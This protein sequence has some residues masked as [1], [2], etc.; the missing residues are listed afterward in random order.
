MVWVDNWWHAQFRAN[1]VKPNACLDVT[2]KAVLH[3][4]PLPLVR[5]HP[6][7]PDLVDR[8]DTVVMAVVQQ[9]REMLKV[10]I[11]MCNAPIYRRTIRGPLDI[12]R[13]AGRQ[14]LFRKPFGIYESHTCQN[15][16]LFD[17]LDVLRSTQ[18]HRQ[19]PMA[20][21]VDLIIHYRVRKILYS[22]ATIDWNF[23]DW[24]QVISVIYGLWHTYKHGCNIIWRT[25]FPL[26][27]YITAP[28]F[29]A[30]ARI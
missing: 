29:E 27:S 5:G 15:Q 17:L 18:R 8:V 12:A 3:T 10:C 1:P 14:Q 19:N 20:L 4:T 13:E 7:L 16:E 2:A 21:L 11:D 25:F 9:H 30:G 28:V 23:P 22:R 6:S 24:L 26:I